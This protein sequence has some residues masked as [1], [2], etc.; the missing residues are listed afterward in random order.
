MGIL[1]FVVGAIILLPLSANAYFFKQLHAPTD[2]R[3]EYCRVQTG[4]QTQSCGM[5]Y[6]EKRLDVFYLPLELASK[7]VQHI[8]SAHSKKYYTNL[9]KKDLFHG[10]LLARGPQHVYNSAQ[11]YFLDVRLILYHS[12]EYINTWE[13]IEGDDPFVRRE[14]Q[15]SFVGWFYGE[16]EEVEAAI[17]LLDRSLYP[18]PYAKNILRSYKNA[19]TIYM[20]DLNLSL[21]ESLHEHQMQGNSEP[22]YIQN[23][24][25]KNERCEIFPQ[26]YLLEEAEGRFTSPDGKRFDITMHCRYR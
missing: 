11:E 23:P 16:N 19:G 4:S 12:Q 26:I 2:I 17:S 5:H 8:T 24:A 20:S 15:R 13:D 22:L 25:N 9:N 1:G 14:N 18:K 10:H 6:G 3:A 21:K 7:I